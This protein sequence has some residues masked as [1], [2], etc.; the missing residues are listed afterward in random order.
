ML[1]SSNLDIYVRAYAKPKQSAAK[2]TDES[3][4]D[5][6]AVKSEQHYAK[7]S[8]MLILDT[9][10]T[11]DEKQTLKFGYFEIYQDGQLEF[12]GIFHNENIIRE[13]ELVILT[14]YCN[15][16][17]IPLMTRKQFNDQIFYPEV[18]FKQTCCV[19]FNL[20]FDI[21][22]IAL[23]FG[24]ARD[25]TMLGGFS[26]KLS[27]NMEFPRILVKHISNTMSFIKFGRS[28][29]KY[30]SGFKGKFVDLRTLGWA[31]R[32]KKYSLESACNEFNTEIQKRKVTQ[33]GKITT[34]YIDYC[35][36][37]VEATHSLF[38]AMLKEY[39][40]YDV[41]LEINKAYS[42]AS[43]GKAL[44]HKMGITEASSKIS[45]IPDTILGYVMS[46]YYGG[47]SEVRIRKTPTPAVYLDFLSMYPTVCVLMDLWKFVSSDHVEYLDCT[48]EVIELVDSITLEKL[49]DKALWKQLTVIVEVEPHGDI[50]PVRAR[51]D[52][53]THGIGINHLEG[54]GKRLWYTIHDV[55][56]S[57]LLTG[58]TPK[59]TKAIRFVPSGLQKDLQPIEF[60]GRQ[61]DPAKD[62]FFKVLIEYRKELQIK[63]KNLPAGSQEHS[64]LQSNQ[65][66]TKIIANA[67]SYG[68]FIEL[69]EENEESEVEVF[70]VDNFSTLRTKVEKTGSMFNPILA[71]L[72]TGASRLML[73]MAEA[74]VS[75]NNVYYAF[76]DTDSIAVNP[77]L[78]KDL[79]A[80]FQRRYQFNTIVDSQSYI[81]RIAVIG[82]VSNPIKRPGS[83]SATK[84]A[85]IVAST[86]VITCGEAAAMCTGWRQG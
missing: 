67:T 31:I 16:N 86:R 34:D 17:N 39:Q 66:I 32:N 65:Y 69:N 85:E 78:A 77:E 54:D 73:G 19:G 13:K 56:V 76:C 71:V 1:Q 79:Q 4:N 45:Q 30:T 36:Y 60:L 59:I 64:E 5:L 6:A 37:D 3:D 29:I 25:K 40:K 80:F 61:I 8:R 48:S 26:F 49:T 24:Y 58:R 38:I 68:I 46:A 10:T 62:D 7:P 55:I 42:P 15:T 75:K 74:F 23:D 11:N 22:R 18:F 2:P 9:E 43:I 83:S 63:A 82:S 70:G 47:R 14:E 33:R 41:N 50:L 72:I 21:S 20:P 52:G 53:Q 81:K 44:L 12:H 27:I 57:K 28:L 35:I 84:H 51:Y